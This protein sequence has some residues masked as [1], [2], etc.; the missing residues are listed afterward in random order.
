MAGFIEGYDKN[1][2]AIG[3]QIEGNSTIF[4]ST[5]LI[6]LPWGCF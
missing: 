1:L 5:A 2:Q 6:L 3:E 4:I